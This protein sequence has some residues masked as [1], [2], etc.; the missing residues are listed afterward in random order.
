M[1]SQIGVESVDDLFSPIPDHIRLKGDLNLPAQRS[2][3]ALRADLSGLAGR[4]TDTSQAVCFMGAGAYDHFIPTVV[5]TLASQNEF[6]TAYTPYQAEASQGALQAFYEYQT[7]VCQLTG[8]DV[9]NASMYD[10]S[11]ALAEAVLMARS[12]TG[13]HKVVCA[14]TLHPEYREVISTYIDNLPVELHTLPCQDGRMK[15]LHLREALDD[16]VAAVLIQQ[17][18]FF[19]QVEQLDQLTAVA[20]TCGAMVIAVVDPISLGLMKTPGELG[21]DVVVAEGQS[22]GVPLSYGGPYIGLM[23]TT[24]KHIRKLPGRLVG[25]TTDNQGR[26]AYCL[27]LQTREQ[28][29]RRERATSNICTNQGL[30]AIRVSVYLATMGP[31]GLR[32]AA[33]M[34][35]NKAHYAAARINE[36]DGYSLRFGGSFFKEFVVQTT[37]DVS[38]VLASLQSQNILGGVPLGRWYPDMNDCFMVAVTENRTREQIDALVDA[39][40]TAP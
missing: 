39:L 10:G 23:A 8:M 35:L 13:R 37:R 36:L 15:A 3:P 29:I 32:R 30:M 27:T 12:V 14:T 31:A 5:D 16:D 2:E 26:R 4:N 6:V 20:K 11:T 40:K 34:S 17:P 21:V 33:E 24:N 7:L 19:G 22:L 1:L 28:H 38:A 9:S 18:N 25:A